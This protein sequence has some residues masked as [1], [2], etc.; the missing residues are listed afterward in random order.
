MSITVKLADLRNLVGITGRFTDPSPLAPDF[1]R[2]LFSRTAASEQA[3]S[4]ATVSGE[5]L[6]RLPSGGCVAV[7][8]GQ[9]QG[10]YSDDWAVLIMGQRASDAYSPAA[11]LKSWAEPEASAA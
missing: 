7:Q 5:Y 3:S 8:S 1:N 9:I 6:K 11:R 10:F 2:I 4:L